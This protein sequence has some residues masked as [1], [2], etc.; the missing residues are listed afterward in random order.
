MLVNDTEQ[1]DKTSN[2]RKRSLVNCSRRDNTVLLVPEKFRPNNLAQISLQA[3]RMAHKIGTPAH[4]AR[5]DAS[6][7][8]KEE[9]LIEAYLTNPLVIGDP[10]WVIIMKVCHYYIPTHKLVLN[11]LLSKMRI[12]KSLSRLYYIHLFT[13]IVKRKHLSY[14]TLQG[15]H[16]RE[17]QKKMRIKKVRSPI[18]SPHNTSQM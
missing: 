17:S 4:D 14:V 1:E 10:A 13:S 15:D 3:K 7:S 12:L 18:K 9:G 6:G 2:P 5:L 8:I 11:T 16:A